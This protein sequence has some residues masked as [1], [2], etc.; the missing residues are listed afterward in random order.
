MF[1]NFLSRSSVAVVDE[2]ALIVASLDDDDYQEILKVLDCFHQGVKGG[3][4]LT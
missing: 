1:K 2:E 4:N 3:D